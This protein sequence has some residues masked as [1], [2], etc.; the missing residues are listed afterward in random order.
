MSEEKLFLQAFLVG[1]LV[2]L[3]TT[4]AILNVRPTEPPCTAYEAIDGKPV[5]IEYNLNK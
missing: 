1:I 2:G 4:F 5:C 3:L